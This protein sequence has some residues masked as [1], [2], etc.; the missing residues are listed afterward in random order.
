MDKP[1]DRM[2]RCRHFVPSP[3]YIA[4][5]GDVGPERLRQNVYRQAKRRRGGIVADFTVGLR[6]NRGDLH[7]FHAESFFNTIYLRKRPAECVLRAVI[8]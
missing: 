7:E 2:T 1:Y 8:G 3:Q 5:F 6:D 4:M